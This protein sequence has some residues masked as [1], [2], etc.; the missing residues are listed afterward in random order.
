MKTKW[1]SSHLLPPRFNSKK[2]YFFYFLFRHTNNQ[3][4]KKIVLKFI[5]TAH[6]S[7]EQKINKNIQLP[8]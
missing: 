5:A 4:G 7:L 3:N 8:I 6:P 1:R 2:L